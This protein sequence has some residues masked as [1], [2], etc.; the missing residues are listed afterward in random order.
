MPDHDPPRT[1]LDSA[2]TPLSWPEEAEDLNETLDPEDWDHYRDVSHRVLDE[3]LDYLQTVSRRPVWRPVPGDVKERLREAAPRAPLPVTEVWDAV[4]ELILPYPT[5]NI[6][7]RFW[8]W[9]H[10]TGTAS[11]VLAEMIAAT[12]NS[13][14]GGREHA[15]VYVERQVIDWFRVLFGFPAGASGILL[16]GTSMATAVGLTVARNAAFCC[17]TLPLSLSSSQRRREKW[18][19]KVTEYSMR[20]APSG[21]RANGDVMGR[22]K[23]WSPHSGVT[24]TARSRE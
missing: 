18:R 3:L 15:P 12:M 13:N 23:D 10:G 8:G 7:P 20:E 9:V 1:A 11:G 4:R 24:G 21:G 2:P 22:S 6:H 5:G 17:S 19:A 16:T 14:L